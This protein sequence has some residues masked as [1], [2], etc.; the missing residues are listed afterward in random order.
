MIGFINKVRI[1]FRLLLV[2]TELR[3]KFGEHLTFHPM[4]QQRPFRFIFFAAAFMSVSMT[5]GVAVAVVYLLFH[6]EL[7]G[8][9][10]GKI[11]N[12]FNSAQ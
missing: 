2:F 10:F 12:A 6:P 7:I 5:I 4:K 11:F 9:F 8:E 1:F 3:F